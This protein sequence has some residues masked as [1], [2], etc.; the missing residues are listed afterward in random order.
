VPL[1]V[2]GVLPILWNVVRSFWIR[3]HLTSLIPAKAR[4]DVSL[5]IDPA[6]GVVIAVLDKLELTSQG[7]L[8]CGR[9]PKT[10]AARKIQE[11]STE[12]VGCSWMGL[13]AADIPT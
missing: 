6:S 5:T 9:R 10:L 1:A 2:L 4:K 7:V 13:Y 3:H 11:I 8:S 12:L